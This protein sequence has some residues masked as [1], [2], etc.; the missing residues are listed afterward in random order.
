MMVWVQ[1][2]NSTNV[3]IFVLRLLFFFDIFVVGDVV[4]PGF[5]L[6]AVRVDHRG[7]VATTR[8]LTRKAK[9]SWRPKPPSNTLGK[10][11]QNFLG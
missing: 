6:F 9:V 10:G 7:P 11:S 5:V 3:G 2:G 8:K 1:I 4:N